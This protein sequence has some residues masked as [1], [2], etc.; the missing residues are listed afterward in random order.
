MKILGVLIHARNLISRV[1]RP[2]YP[3]TDWRPPVFST[4]AGLENYARH[5]LKWQADPI[6]GLLDHVKTVKAMNWQIRNDEKA[7][8]DCDDIATWLGWMLLRAGFEKVYRVNVCRHKHVIC[9]FQMEVGGEYRYRTFSNMSLLDGHSG[10]V[11]A[12][13]RRWCN[14]ANKPFTNLYFAERLRLRSIL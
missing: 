5:F 1:A 9:V 12:A 7:R 11:K 10:S 8:G 2:F 4:P 3:Q 13:V 6:R 14:H